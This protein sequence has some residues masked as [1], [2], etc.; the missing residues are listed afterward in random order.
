MPTCSARTFHCRR[1]KK[2]RP[3]RADDLQLGGLPGVDGLGEQPRRGAD[4]VRVEPAAQP[5]VGG[6]HHHQDAVVA[7]VLEQRVR[8]GVARVARA[9]QDLHHLPRV[10]T[11]REHGLLRAA[12]LGRGDHLHGLRDLLRVLDAAD[13]AS[14]VDE[15]GHLLSVGRGR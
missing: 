10:R 2:S 12:E 8:L 9:V 13:P 11:R 3:L 7:V 4:D 5:L 15:C 14:D 6:D 1:L